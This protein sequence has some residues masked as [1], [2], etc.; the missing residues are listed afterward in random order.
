MIIMLFIRFLSDSPVG[1][2]IEACDVFVFPSAFHSPFEVYWCVSFKQPLFQPCLT[3]SYR[4][5]DYLGLYKYLEN[6]DKTALLRV[7][8]CKFRDIKVNPYS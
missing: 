3:L 1:R 7:Q 8:V 5:G 4:D 6:R 2:A